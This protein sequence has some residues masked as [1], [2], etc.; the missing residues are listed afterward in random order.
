[1]IIHQKNV[2]TAVNKYYALSLLELKT[3]VPLEFEMVKTEVT[4][5]D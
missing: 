3:N 2:I 4:G 1:M 5:V